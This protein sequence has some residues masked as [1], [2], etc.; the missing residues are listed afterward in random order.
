MERHQRVIVFKV[1]C[2][3]F[4]GGVDN[5][6][7][8]PKQEKQICLKYLTPYGFDLQVAAL[9]FAIYDYSVS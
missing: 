5:L 9:C 2:V 1:Q 8:D 3:A 6:Y 7:S 4:R